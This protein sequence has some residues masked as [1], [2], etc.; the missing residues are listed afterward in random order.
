[1]T[2]DPEVSLV[3]SRNRVKRRRFPPR[4]H[5]Q[6]AQANR[7]PRPRDRSQPSLAN[8]RPRD[9]SQP[10]QANQRPREHN[11]PTLAND[12]HARHTGPY[13]RVK[14]TTGPVHPLRGALAPHFPDG[15][16]LVTP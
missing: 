6:P 14:H 15:G 10:A 12:D 1:M 7:R 5:S 16:C 11:Q 3:A 9:H 8:Q 4:D 2:S 13:R